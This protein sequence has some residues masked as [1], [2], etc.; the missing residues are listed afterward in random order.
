[1]EKPKKLLGGRKSL[2]QHWGGVRAM[3]VEKQAE[4]PSSEGRKLP[5]FHCS[6][7]L[8]VIGNSVPHMLSLCLT[9]KLVNLFHR[10]G[11]S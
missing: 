6:F 3:E 9:E 8:L 1:M 2:I 10:G 11:R 5:P 4:S 7:D